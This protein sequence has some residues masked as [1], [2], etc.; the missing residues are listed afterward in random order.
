MKRIVLFRHAKSNWSADYEG[1]HERPL[2]KRGRKAAKAM[3]RFLATTRIHPDLVVSS[4]AVRARRTAELAM[5]AGDWNAVLEITPALYG[6]DVA[7][8]VGLLGE[9]PPDCDTVVLVGHEPTWSATVAFLGGGG[10]VRMPT[11]A[12]ACLDADVTSWSE[13]DSA[14]AVLRWLVTPK[15]VDAMRR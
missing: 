12:M 5:S 8:V 1:D 10:V 11:A 3:G 14:S 4:S 7:D 15:I 6:T 13:I 9:M 2:Q